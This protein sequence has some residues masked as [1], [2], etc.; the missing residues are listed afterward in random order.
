MGVIDHLRW[1]GEEDLA[2]LLRERPVLLDHCGT[3]AE[4]AYFIESPYALSEA[5]CHTNALEHAAA[6]VIA[7]LGPVH[8]A[9]VA[10]ALG[11]AGSD[12]TCV[13]TAITNL[14]RLLLATR[15][16]DGRIAPARGLPHRFGRPLGLGRP[17]A[18]M[19]PQVDIGSLR[20]AAVLFGLPK[21]G[22]KA[23]L[24]AALS[25]ALSDSEMVRGAL[26]GAPP[27]TDDLVERLLDA[28][29]VDV[30]YGRP[31]PAAAWLIER[32]ML[33]RVE[34]YGGLAELPREA[35]LALRGPVLLSVTSA[36][37]PLS[38]RVV[39]DVDT[40][41][42]HN[43]GAVISLLSSVV[44]ALG[45]E[46]AKAIQSG[47]LGVRDLRRLAKAAE[48]DE[49]TAGRLL[50]MARSG[51]L[52]G[53]MVTVVAP[54]PGRRT[55]WQPDPAPL[56]EWLPT[57]G[58][59]RWL[60]LDPGRRWATLA[61]AWLDGCAW[62]S[63]A[64][65]RSAG[66]KTAGAFSRHDDASEA[67]RLRRLVL[68]L[69]SSL[70]AGEAPPVAEL[71]SAV[72]WHQIRS[73]VWGHTGSLTLTEEILAEA[74]LLG[75]VANGALT[76]LG[77]S[78]LA[79]PEAAARAAGEM[80]PAPVREI[81]VQADLSAIASGPLDRDVAEELSSMADVESRGVATIWRF[82]EASVRRALDHGATPERM[83]AF[84][85][86]H[87]SK[88]V[89]QPLRYL[90]NDAARRHGKLRVAA[91]ASVVTSDDPAL[92]AEVRA[93][94]RTAKLGLRELAPT[95]LASALPMDVVLLTLRAAGFLPVEERGDGGVSVVRPARRRAPGDDGSPARRST[96]L[97][98]LAR[99][100]LKDR[101][102]VVRGAGDLAGLAALA[103]QLG[104]DPYHVGAYVDDP[105]DEDPG[106]WDDG[107]DDDGM[108]HRDAHELLAEAADSGA[109]VAVFAATGRR[110]GTEV[111]G[112]VAMLTRATVVIRDA[113]GRKKTLPLDSILSIMEEP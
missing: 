92:L 73:V 113:H 96:D 94:R 19:L 11:L 46:P 86:D 95:V 98:A 20:R 1:L 61:A 54:K 50:E 2:A 55:R 103:G 60:A 26:A 102:D 82:S 37:P 74:E 68:D 32:M 97:V 39:R 9:E 70:G 31:P 63:R 56:V 17:L 75:V 84:L 65:A 67:P 53:T 59:D 45:A 43:S 112:T 49:A 62:P 100:L 58:Y 93:A 101:S 81:L 110:S 38:G 8:L 4:L 29:V 40:S 77:R 78:L 21:A 44:D 41:A 33:V 36:P 24:A 109:E 13:G 47:E 69:L 72:S 22:A 107:G 48:T 14:E 42:S 83:L 10:A 12:S 91:A 87:A 79:D 111:V 88:G 89:P 3:M 105:G 5:L 57:A 51:G 30:G 76:S 99:R 18:A 6:E 64:G 66:G 106:W 85:D 104:A 27:G 28:V 35:A 80:L 7:A 16:P 71:A 15:M 108:Q 52:V 90:V 25:G 34:A 23:A